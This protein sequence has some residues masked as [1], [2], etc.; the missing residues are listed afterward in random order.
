MV[1]WSDAVA[2]GQTL[3][4]G[5][6]TIRVGRRL[7]LVSASLAHA[8]STLAE[9]EEPLTRDATATVLAGALPE[10]EARALRTR[11]WSLMQRQ[12]VRD[13][14]WRDWL[15]GLLRVPLWRPPR[16]LVRR[17]Q[18]RVLTRPIVTA[19][20]VLLV[21]TVIS[22]RIGPPPPVP[23]LALS[24]SQWVLLWVLVGA[25][26]VI[27]EAGHLLVAAHYGVRARSVGVALFYL[28][29]AG[30]TDVSDA[31]LA[32][33]R[34]RV[35]IALGGLLF[36]TVPLVAGYWVWR[37]TGASVGVLYCAANIAVAVF[38]LIPLLRLD[39]YWVLSH[40]IEEPNLRQRSRAQLA[41]LLRPQGRTAPWT[42]RRGALMGLF[43]ALS[44]VFTL[45]MYVGGLMAL[46]AVL[47]ARF[48]DLVLVLAVVA[49]LAT[50]ARLMLPVA[51]HRA[52]ERRRAASD[53]GA[54]ARPTE[55]QSADMVV[56]PRSQVIT[57]RSPVVTPRPTS[58]GPLYV[59]PFRWR[60]RSGSTFLLGAPHAGRQLPATPAL[61]LLLDHDV[62]DLRDQEAIGQDNLRM[63]EQERFLLP[64]QITDDSSVSRQVGF[65]SFWPGDPNV[66]QENLDRATV[67]VLGLGSL[68][69]Q[70]S[71]LLAAA[72]VGRLIIC[73]HDRVEVSNLN[74]QLLYGRADVGRHKADVARERLL[75]VNPDLST[76]A[77][78]RFVETAADVIEIAHGADIVVRA[79]D[80]P[81]EVVLIV[82]EACRKMG[83]PH[84]GGGFVDWW[85]VAGPFVTADGRCMACLLPLL[86][87]RHAQNRRTAIFGP[88]TFWVSSHIAGDVL[89]Y[90]TGLGDP[91]LYERIVLHDGMS[92]REMTEQLIPAQASCHVCGY[93]SASAEARDDTA[94]DRSRRKPGRR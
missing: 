13:T 82:D 34:A 72:G 26:T 37:V 40:F 53:P 9:V 47:P 3:P 31:W 69:A 78:H 28:Q 43:A 10:P 32:P 29:P 27:H 51:I 60:A 35:V 24:P 42:G 61:D 67:A 56:T 73:D 5:Q 88:L 91:L 92:G 4:S 38:N 62:V 79:L 68:G 1:D 52:A 87:M 94:I 22:T 6:V 84:V 54:D 11:L 36:Q 77:S 93:A 75:A 12:P 89:R 14:L 74:R 80:N 85:A 25:T 66:R 23:T 64:W 41:Y 81:P 46:R 57:S 30:Y 2:I 48:H 76:E 49:V 63:L 17:L 90:L 45:G 19:W 18:G 50:L 7:L 33:R 65:F 71:Y 83:V 20:L 16:S 15:R 59:N 21:G 8:V 58:R 86:P 39:G 44:G 55:T 70:V